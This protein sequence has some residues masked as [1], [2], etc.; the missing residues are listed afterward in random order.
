M[1]TSSPF[2]PSTD[3]RSGSGMPCNS[4]QEPPSREERNAQKLNPSH[5]ARRQTFGLRGDPRRPRRATLSGDLIVLEA[6]TLDHIWG[7]HVPGAIGCFNSLLAEDLDM[8]GKKELYVAG[9]RG[10][11]RFV[12]PGEH[13]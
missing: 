2:A 10:L 11:W 3:P 7:T 12:L 6:D 9:S 13:Q 5:A 8:D 4:P 1:A